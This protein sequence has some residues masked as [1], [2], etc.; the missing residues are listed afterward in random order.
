MIIS[1]PPLLATQPSRLPVFVDGN[2]P[3]DLFCTDEE[4]LQCTKTKKPAAKKLN[5]LR[6]VVVFLCA[7][8]AYLVSLW[9][10]FSTACRE[11]TPATANRMSRMPFSAPASPHHPHIYTQRHHCPRARLSNQIVVRPDQRRQA[12]KGFPARG[13]HRTGQRADDQGH[14]PRA[15]PRAVGRHALHRRASAGATKGAASLQLADGPARERRRPKST[16]KPPM[17][18]T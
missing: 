17:T 2:R 10:Y 14:A 11:C 13:G 9:P 6:R 16:L 15:R 5:W 8:G 18:G 3:S 12:T 1:P 7:R 4:F